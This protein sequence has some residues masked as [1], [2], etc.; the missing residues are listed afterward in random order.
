ML[1]R[2]ALIGVFAMVAFAG[3]L[4]PAD[5]K[6]D[7]KDPYAG[8]VARAS[9]EWQRTLKRMQ[10]AKGVSA[11]LWA[12]EPHVA[13]I[14][15]FAFDEK[16]RCYVA[17]TFR[18]H[19]GVTDNRG[20]MYWLDED[21]AARTV[22][23]RVALHQKYSKDKFERT[24]ERDRDRVRLLEDTAGGGKA[25]KA[26]TFSDDFGHAA[27]GIGAGLLA[28]NGNVYFTNIPDLWLLKD[29]KGT[30]TAD[31]KQSLGTGF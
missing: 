11:D 26:S 19:A 20:H 30:G 16:G 3:G 31:V 12:A 1:R 15:A 18:L 17:E 9:D 29:T 14:V 28:R 6:T 4:L 7:D 22:E 10:L 21:L 25:D 27:D 2:F 5:D 13:N 8:R 23:D 24:Y